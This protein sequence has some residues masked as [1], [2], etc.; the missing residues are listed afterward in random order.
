[1]SKLLKSTGERQGTS[2][3]D[4]LGD[5]ERNIQTE[6]DEELLEIVDM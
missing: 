1:M 6:M 4:A 5:L 2:T 3:D